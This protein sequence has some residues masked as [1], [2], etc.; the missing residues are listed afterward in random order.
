M[1]PKCKRKAVRECQDANDALETSYGTVTLRKYRELCALAEAAIEE[2]STLREDWE[3][4]ITEGGEFFVSYRC[5]CGECGFD[6][7]FSHEEQ[8]LKE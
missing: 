5:Q 8:A 2:T 7:A 1:C 6:Y 3:I 4:G